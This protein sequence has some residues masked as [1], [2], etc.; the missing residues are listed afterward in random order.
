MLLTWL[1][2][3]IGRVV[4]KYKC[5][6]CGRGNCRLYRWY[7]CSHIELMCTACAEAANPPGKY[8]KL[9]KES[10]PQRHSIG[11]M[12]AAVPDGEGNYWGYTSVPQNLVEWWD[13]LPV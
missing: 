5:H 2:R 3:T 12:V 11:G 1:W 7:S 9:L 4:D 6:K 10:D 8:E 13:N